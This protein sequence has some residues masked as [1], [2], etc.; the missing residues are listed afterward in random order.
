M[1]E[2]Q[3]DPFDPFP[4]ESVPPRGPQLADAVAMVVAWWVETPALAEQIREVRYPGLGRLLDDLAR[5]A[6]RDPR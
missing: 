1:A 3:T 6:G 4:P 2:P 5:A